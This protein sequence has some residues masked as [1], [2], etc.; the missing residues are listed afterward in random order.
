MGCSDHPGTG[1]PVG[2]GTGTGMDIWTHEKPVTKTHGCIY[3]NLA[4]PPSRCLAHPP[5]PSTTH[6]H[7]RNHTQTGHIRIT[8]SVTNRLHGC[9]KNPPATSFHHHHFGWCLA[10]PQSTV[11]WLSRTM[12]KGN[13]GEKEEEEERRTDNEVGGRR[14]TGREEEREV[15]G[16]PPSFAVAPPPRT[17]VPPATP[18]RRIR[19]HDDIDD[20][21]CAIHPPWWQ[22]Q[23]SPYPVPRAAPQSPPLACATQTHAY[24]ANA[25][26]SD[27]NSVVV[28]VMTCQ[29]TRCTCC[30]ARHLWNTCRRYPITSSLIM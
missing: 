22:A 13:Q 21:W 27:D 26:C 6:P 19:P 29:M 30:G 14:R 7:L 5:P 9:R 15:P 12:H 2:L 20:A 17:Q 25:A 18:G 1:I 16:E 4:Q 10:Q 8:R 3:R 28:C 11:Q 23:A 24:M